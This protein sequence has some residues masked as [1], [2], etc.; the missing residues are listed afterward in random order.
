M[1]SQVTGYRP[2]RS[3][4]NLPREQTSFDV[5]GPVIDNTEPV[6]LDADVL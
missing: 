6:D 2:T 1:E 4:G 5:S 3:L